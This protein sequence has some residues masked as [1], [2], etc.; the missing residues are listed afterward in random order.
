MEATLEQKHVYAKLEMLYIDQQLTLKKNILSAIVLH[1]MIT[2]KTT[3]K[4]YW[5]TILIPANLGAK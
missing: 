5:L 2:C 3:A 4:N 1:A